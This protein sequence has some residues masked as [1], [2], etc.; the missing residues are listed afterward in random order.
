LLTK[1]YEHGHHI[2]NC[3]AQLFIVFNIIGGGLGSGGDKHLWN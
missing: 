1:R 2:S 3:F